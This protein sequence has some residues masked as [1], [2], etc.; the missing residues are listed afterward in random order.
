MAG[1]LA[2][3]G[4]APSVRARV[5]G[6]QCR[7]SRP[8]GSSGSAGPARRLLASCHEDTARP[9]LHRGAHL[10]GRRR[11]RHG[12][13]LPR[14]GRRRPRAR[15]RRALPGPGGPP[16]P[17]L[18]PL[19]RRPGRH[20]PRRAHPRPP[21]PHRLP[22]AAGQGRFR[23]P[24]DVHRRDRRPGGHRP[25]GQRPPAA[26]GRPLR[27]LRRLLPA[28]P[29]TP[30]VR[31]RR[32]RADAEADRAGGPRAPAEAGTGRHP[33]AA[34]G[35]T[36][37]RLRHRRTATGGAP[38]GLQ[39]RP[40]SCAPPAPAPP[41]RPARGG[42]DRGRVDVR[43]PAAPAAGPAA[44]GRRGQPHGG[45]GRERAD[46]GLR[47]RPHRAG[48]PGAAPADAARGHPGRPGLRRQ[49]DGPRRAGL[50]PTGGVARRTAAPPRG[51]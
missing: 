34:V 46:P 24:R 41:G 44:A 9:H 11:H 50:L 22:A 6:R 18:G 21:R 12:Q 16:E 7:W 42:H 40:R 1:S 13:P 32:R 45:P 2:G 15:R 5:A 51:A 26:G 8:A 23:R 29:R 30:A 28:P 20:R 33:H 39:R 38:G 3:V 25:A 17:Q 14:G 27:Q 48:A 36:H 43:R 31:R 10:P 19:P 4:P 35:G 47:R 49:P 37:P